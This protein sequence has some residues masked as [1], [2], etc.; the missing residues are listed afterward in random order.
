MLLYRAWNVI[1]VLLYVEI[2]TYF[3]VFSL[4][5]MKSVSLSMS[6]NVITCTAIQMTI[7]SDYDYKSDK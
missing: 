4:H 5:L 2:E 6:L 3:K 7:P 1:N